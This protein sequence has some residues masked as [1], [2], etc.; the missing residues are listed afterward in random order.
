MTCDTWHVTFDM[1]HLTHRG[2]WTLSQNFPSSNGLWFMI[3]WRFGLHNIMYSIFIYIVHFPSW[4]N[5][6]FKYWPQ[7]GRLNFASDK[8][9]FTLQSLVIKGAGTAPLV[10]IC[11]AATEELLFSKQ[12]WQVF[13][14]HMFNTSP[15]QNS[16]LSYFF[17]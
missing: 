1:W 14:L 13:L 6:S 4:P 17:L 15:S 11:W 9:N 10:T 3:F 16:L 2:W 8:P 12:V 7:S 5:N